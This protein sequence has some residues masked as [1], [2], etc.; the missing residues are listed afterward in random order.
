MLILNISHSAIFD[1]LRQYDSLWVKYISLYVVFECLFR[2]LRSE[3]GSRGS[4]SE[5]RSRLS[6]VERNSRNHRG[7]LSPK[8]R[9]RMRDRT[10][11]WSCKIFSR[12][13]DTYNDDGSLKHRTTSRTC[14]SET[15]TSLSSTARKAVQLYR[16]PNKPFIGSVALSSLID[17]SEESLSFVLNSS[18]LLLTSDLLVSSFF[19]N[20]SAF[21][22]ELYADGC[23]GFCAIGKRY[24]FAHLRRLLKNAMILN[25]SPD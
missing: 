9:A 19:A 3:N 6:N 20:T 23:E 15:I 1:D 5:F 21:Q 25:D 13:P 7:Q 22:W 12:W 10:L 2:S 16:D 17:I 11:C 8:E 24:L 14:T 4:G 18:K